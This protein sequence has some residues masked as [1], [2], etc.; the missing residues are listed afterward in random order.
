MG[1]IFTGIDQDGQIINEQITK[2]MVDVVSVDDGD[3]D[4]PGTQKNK[5]LTK[6][7]PFI[8]V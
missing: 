3:G 2:A 6:Q 1:E 5:R 7:Q 8:T 4:L